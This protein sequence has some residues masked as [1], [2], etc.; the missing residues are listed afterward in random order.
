MKQG[1]GMEAREWCSK[2]G[3]DDGGGGVEVVVQ[4]LRDTVGWWGGWRRGRGRGFCDDI[5][6]GVG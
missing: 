1:D 3:C 2:V 6:G 5:A 4:I